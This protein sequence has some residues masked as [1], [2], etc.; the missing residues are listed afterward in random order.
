MTTAG[1]VLVMA[2]APVAGR[3]KTR[4]CPPLRPEQAADLAAAAL[5]DTLTA[6]GGHR[7]VVA[8]HGPLAAAERG[9]ALGAA[10]RHCTVV[11][12]RGSTFGDRLAAAHL[13]AAADGFGPVLQVGMDTPQ[14]TPLLLRSAFDTLT[15]PSVDA[16]LAPATDGGWW[17]LGLRSAANAR[18]LRDV[19]MSRPDTCTRTLAALESLGLRVAT[20]PVLTDVD[21]AADAERVSQSAPATGFARTWRELSVLTGASLRAP[22]A[23]QLHLDPLDLQAVSS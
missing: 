7:T 23:G 19:P 18:V 4:L 10:L 5:L 3:V 8:L 16:V 9:R 1:T 14:L 12:Q 20:L 13:D 11:R 2:K 6:A 22:V 15:D 17:A 21:T